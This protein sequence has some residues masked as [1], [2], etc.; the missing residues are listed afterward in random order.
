[1]EKKYPA[2]RFAADVTLA[3]AAF[4]GFFWLLFG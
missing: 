3:A 4:G 2:I 1:M